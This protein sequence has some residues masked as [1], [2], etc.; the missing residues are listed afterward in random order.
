MICHATPQNLQTDAFVFLS[1]ENGL[2]MPLLFALA[3]LKPNSYRPHQLSPEIPTPLAPAEASCLPRCT[4]VRS[5]RPR[6]ALALA[7]WPGIPRPVVGVCPAGHKPQPPAT[8]RPTRGACSP[9][10]WS[11]VCTARRVAATAAGSFLVSCCPLLLAAEPLRTPAIAAVCC[12]THVASAPPSS[13][14]GQVHTHAPAELAACS[15]GSQQAGPRLM[16]PF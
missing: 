2:I 6:L 7:A 3:S 8:R 4:C 14:P 12:G 16:S 11:A 15:T 1:C 10:Y 13:R 9:Y 5:P